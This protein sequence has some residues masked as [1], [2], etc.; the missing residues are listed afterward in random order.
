MKIIDLASLKT[1]LIVWFSREGDDKFE[2]RVG[3]AIDLTHAEII[4][5][6]RV[7]KM[8]TFLALGVD[9]GAQSLTLPQDF[10]GF[11]YAPF[12]A[13]ILG[14]PMRQ[15]SFSELG[16][17]SRSSPD[18]IASG[19]A[20]AVY[21]IHGSKFE[22][23]P[24]ALSALTFIFPYRRGITPLAVVDTNFLVEDCP[25]AYFFG[26]MHFLHRF[27]GDEGR[28]EPVDEEY[29]DFLKEIG[30]ADTFEQYGASP[31]TQTSLVIPDDRPALQTSAA[32]VDP[33][34]F[35]IGVGNPLT[36]LG[37]AAL[38]F[39]ALG[40]KSTPDFTIPTESGA[41]IPPGTVEFD[42]LGVKSLPQ[43]FEASTSDAVQLVREEFFTANFG[44]W[45]S[46]GFEDPDAAWSQIRG[47]T[48]TTTGGPDGGSSATTRIP[49]ANNTHAYVEADD[50]G[51]VFSLES[52]RF[53]AG[54]GLLTLTFDVHM[55]FGSQGGIADGTLRMQGWNGSA[56]VDIGDAIVGSQQL[57][58]STPFLPSTDFDTYNSAGFSNDDF[59]FRLQATKGASQF[60]SNYDFSVDNAL[61]TG[62]LTAIVEQPDPPVVVPPTAGTPTAL[63]GGD[64]APWTIPAADIATRRD[65][66]NL[67]NQIYTAAPEININSDRFTPVIYD[68]RDAN[69]TIQFTRTNFRFGGNLD[70]GAT[71]PWNFGLFTTPFDFDRS[72]GDSYTILIDSVTGKTFEFFQSRVRN[73]RLEA[74]RGTEL[75]TGVDNNGPDANIFTK[76]N[77]NRNSRACG[78]QHVVGVV[79]RSEIDAGRIPHCMTL[80]YPTPTRFAKEPFATKGVGSPTSSTTSNRGFMGLRLVWDGLTDQ[81]VANWLA[82]QPASTRP[83]LQI[84]AN[85]LREFGCFTSDLSGAPQNLRGSTQWE[86]DLSADWR[87]VGFNPNA[88]G[89]ALHDLLRPN[90]R[91][92]RALVAGVHASGQDSSVVCYPN[93]TYPGSHPCSGVF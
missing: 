90:R 22:F 91:K 10:E 80:A 37:V 76:Q 77:G 53:D 6:L 19:G 18:S 17:F 25:N 72:D 47:P 7:R 20:P 71:I 38:S 51:T 5:R 84:V 9:A 92:C 32:G 62:P 29:S 73:G 93:V 69:T 12:I 42:V 79:L 41:V 67:V 56:W 24:S 49:Q 36:G 63:Y 48:P 3:V 74:S 58:A 64:F 46:P 88:N 31:L 43:P 66:T 78:L 8:Q 16:K 4:K 55:R 54:E 57:T 52:P 27:M 50:L 59:R 40:I 39:D 85:C 87:D 34:V 61:V 14:Q 44:E 81:D 86:H 21:A 1:A 83:V 75:K 60:Q 65:S 13:N 30:W 28:A 70:T 35:E 26:A 33:L 82:T 89:F 15:V 11:V 68:L 2:E 23:R 45:N